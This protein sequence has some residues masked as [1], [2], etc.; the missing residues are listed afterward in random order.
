[1]AEN[2]SKNKKAVALKYDLEKDNAPIITASGQGSI[3]KK[4]IE[5]ARENNISIESNQDIIDILIKVEIGEE[6]PAELYQAVAEI[7]SFIYNL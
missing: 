4:I 1:M 3:A 7:L 5:T 2:E 6:I